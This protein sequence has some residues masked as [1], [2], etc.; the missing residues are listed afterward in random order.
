KPF[1]ELAVGDLAEERDEHARDNRHEAV[2][3]EDPRGQTLVDVAVARFEVQLGEADAGAGADHAAGVTSAR[4]HPPPAALAD[5]HLVL[6]LRADTVVDEEVVRS[7]AT[8]LV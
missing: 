5:Q 7:E 8:G 3:D 6:A 1:L 2:L 4:E